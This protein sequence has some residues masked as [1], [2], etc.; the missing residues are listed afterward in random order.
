MMHGISRLLLGVT[1]T[2]ANMVWLWSLAPPP[3]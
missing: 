2:L 3:L 1:G